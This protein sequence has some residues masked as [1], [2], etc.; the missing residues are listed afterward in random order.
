MALAVL[1]LIAVALLAGCATSAAASPDGSVTSCA[2]YA[3]QSIERHV[4][5][6]AL[7]AGCQGLT[8]E[9]VSLAAGTAI[10]EAAD[11]T[12]RADGE[13]GK[14]AVRRLTAEAAQWVS[15]LITQ[16]P[17]AQARPSVPAVAESGGTGGG[18]LG[19][20]SEFAVQ[21]A[22]LIAWFVTALSGAYLLLHWLLAGG[23]L[24]G[25]V[26]GGS[27]APPAAAAGHAGFA[28]AGFLLWTVFTI[29]GWAWLAWT[30]LVI[31]AP[32]AGLGMGVLLLGLPAPTRGGA[33]VRSGER[34]RSGKR[35][36]AGKTGVP[37]LVIGGHG[38]AAATL[39][40]L[41]ITATVAS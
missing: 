8:R 23:R 2:G 15:V 4:R 12:A 5:V 6:T 20:V 17:P 21:I 14:A 36:R 34:A 39:L 26:R 28:V 25:R 10:R 13:T 9:Q 3:Y 32:V 22:A 16:P 7:P 38:I 35:A 11:A 27:S 1:G 19:G 30:C 33:T 37:W 29:T 24:R 18:R 41:V 40:I 31:L